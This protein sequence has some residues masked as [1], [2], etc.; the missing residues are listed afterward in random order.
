MLLKCS[1][2]I[3]RSLTIFAIV[4]DLLVEAVEVLGVPGEGD[5]V[6]RHGVPGAHGEEPALVV[7]AHQV[8]QHRPVIDEGVQVP[9]VI[10][11]EP[12]SQS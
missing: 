6:A 11:G 2:N 7:L 12:H 1:V 5:P 9:G 10:N 8:V 4:H 3:W